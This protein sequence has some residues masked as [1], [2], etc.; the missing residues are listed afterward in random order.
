MIV[1]SNGMTQLNGWKRESNPNA[2]SIARD[3]LIGELEILKLGHVRSSAIIDLRVFLEASGDRPIEVWRAPAGE[4]IV[5]GDSDECLFLTGRTA[6]VLRGYLDEQTVTM[7]DRFDM[8]Q[9]L[10]AM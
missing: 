10:H 3:F 2:G 1:R 7:Q 4:I 6:S 5:A 8:T 9:R